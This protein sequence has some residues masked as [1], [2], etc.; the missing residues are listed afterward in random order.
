MYIENNIARADVVLCMI[1]QNYKHSEI[2]QNEVGA[3]WALKKKIIQIVLSDCSFDSVGW[4]L[5]LDKAIKIDKSASLD[6]LQEKF[7]EIF[8]LP[9]KSPRLWNP[10]VQNFLSVIRT[11]KN[12]DDSMNG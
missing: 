12:N 10:H 4:L 2:C 5:N 1:S 11:F 9:V 3:A 8:S 7:C 6:N